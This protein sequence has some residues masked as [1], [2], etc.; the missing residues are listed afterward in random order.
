M[1]VH[2]FQH[3]PFEGLGSIEGWLEAR[4][5]K[6]T[7]TRFFESAR[8]PRVDEIEWLIIMGGP[9]SVNDQ[10]TC[11][12]IG[13]EKA[14]IAEAIARKKVVLGICLGAQLI[15]SS[16]GAEVH[17][18]PQ[19]EIGW[20][21]VE[22]TERTGV[23]ALPARAEVFHWHG[24]TFELPAGARG[25]ARSAA[26]ANQAFAIGDRVVGFQFHLETTMKSARAMIA[27][28]GSELVPGRFVQT[29]AE[30]LASTG[31]F[32]RINAIMTGVL[33][34]LSAAPSP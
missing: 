8:L 28:C 20:F 19:P 22:R 17:A 1:R 33:E 26:C 11:P 18:N 2:Y 34:S 32:D 7:S 9:M 23:P 30:I 25:I 4:S 12:W 31:R 27:A 10:G 16:M 5:A 6:V 21:P 3:V 14:F 29:E 24:D 15:A 13:A